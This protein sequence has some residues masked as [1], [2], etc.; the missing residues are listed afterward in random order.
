[1]D[2]L[3]RET[4]ETNYE[5]D[6]VT[7]MGIFDDNIRNVHERCYE[8]NLWRKLLKYEIETVRMYDE[9]I[10]IILRNNF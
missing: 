8:K 10:R 2:T 7:M 5:G 6:D 9:S 3:W 4:L 1:M